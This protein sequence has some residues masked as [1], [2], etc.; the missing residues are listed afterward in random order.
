MAIDNATTEHSA[1]FA[2]THIGKPHDVEYISSYLNTSGI[3][4]FRTRTSNYNNPEEFLQ[5]EVRWIVF[6]AK[7]RA[8]SEYQKIVIDSITDGVTR[9]LES[10]N[11]SSVKTA[12]NEVQLKKI[13]GESVPASNWPYDYFSLVELA[14]IETKVDFH[15]ARFV[16]ESGFTTQQSAF[17]SA[18]QGSE[19]MQFEVVEGQDEPES[20]TTSSSANVAEKMVFR[21]LLL[22]DTDVPSTRVF[23]VSDA[24]I[25]PGTEQVFVNGILQSIGSGNDYTI[26]GT[27]LTLTY[28]LNQ[29]DSVVVS[30]VKE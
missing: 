19:P 6:K 25:A 27:Q 7:Q 4:M 11:N 29:G 20:A 17:T 22:A 1:P 21:E 26:S 10:I 28:D 16:K 23:N 12:F 2:R 3:D 13:R 18:E 15:D 30:Y 24:A 9:N 14:K 5:N 8:I